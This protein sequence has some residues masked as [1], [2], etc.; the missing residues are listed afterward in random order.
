MITAELAEKRRDSELTRWP[1]LDTELDR[2]ISRQ[3]NVESRATKL[4]S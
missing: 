1:L 4:R 3:K 2:K